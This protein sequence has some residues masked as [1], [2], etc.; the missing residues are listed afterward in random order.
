M[1]VLAVTTV[2]AVALSACATSAPRVAVAPTSAAKPQKPI[3]GEVFLGVE[4]PELNTIDCDT[5]EIVLVLDRPAD[6][7]VV[8]IAGHRK[9]LE[10][11]ARAERGGTRWWDA[12]IPEMGLR[13]PPFSL[14][15]DWRGEW[16]GRPQVRIPVRLQVHYPN[17]GA[18]FQVKRPT[19]APVLC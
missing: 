7:A 4:C 14:E 3:H 10:P 13:E 9:R 19:L 6:R 1:K 12:T 17:G 11:G 8:S 15:T 2:T 5:V 18:A 16:S